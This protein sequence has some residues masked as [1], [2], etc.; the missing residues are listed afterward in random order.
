[1]IEIIRLVKQYGHAR[2]QAS[3]ECALSTGCSD[4]AAI[5]HLVG[6]NEL[7]RSRPDGLH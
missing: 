6:A 5:R 3:V 4:A 1:M 7:A 2:L